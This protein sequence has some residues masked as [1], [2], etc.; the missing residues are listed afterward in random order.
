MATVLEVHHCVRSNERPGLVRQVG[1]VRDVRVKAQ[2]DAEVVLLVR[3]VR[4]KRRDQS[5][6]PRE[7]HIAA[8]AGDHRRLVLERDEVALA[9]EPAGFEPEF[10][11]LNDGEQ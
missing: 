7:L 5:A 8:I 11:R 4:L 6:L 9:E 2:L 3:G 10:R 1:L